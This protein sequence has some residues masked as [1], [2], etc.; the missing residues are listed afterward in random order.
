MIKVLIP[1]ISDELTDHYLSK[2]GYQVVTYE[3]FDS[4]HFIMENVD[5]SAIMIPSVVFP[6]EVYKRMPNLKIV[7]VRGVGYDRLDVDSATKHNVWVTNTPGANAQSVAELALMNILML[8]RRY[9]E[10]KWRF[11]NNDWIG[12]RQLLGG[13]IGNKT[14]GILGYGHIGQ[15]LCKFLT[16][17]GIRVLLYERG[18][19]CATTGI[20]VDWDTLFRQSDYVSI[21]LALVPET[22]HLVGWHEFQI[23]KAGSSII[24]LARGEIID[25]SALICA[26]QTGAIS[27]A[28]L[29]VFENEPLDRRNVLRSMPNVLL[30]PHIGASTLEANRRMAEIASKQIDLVLSGQSPEYPVNN[31]NK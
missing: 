21:H 1:K 19:H 20:Y 22:R 5:A 17:L 28:A 30:T 12:G 3:K 2:R 23:M 6:N 27:S 8:S 14:V 15:I 29:D 10:V 13:E 31:L 7:A 25:E 11:A 9:N 16:A 24:N 18:P 26:L 4:D